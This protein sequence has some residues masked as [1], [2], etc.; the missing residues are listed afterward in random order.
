MG[1]IFNLSRRELLQTGALAGGGLLLGVY[2]PEL[3]AADAKNSF[4]PNAFVRIGS[5]ELVTVIVNHTEMGQGPFT[6]VP[7]LVAEELE[8]DWKNVRFEAAPVAAVYNHSVYGMQMTGG[9]SST[10]S[11]APSGS[12]AAGASK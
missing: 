8:A 5:D 10:W 6:T 2:V 4:A 11:A 7:M 12:L 1:D 9:S 3:A